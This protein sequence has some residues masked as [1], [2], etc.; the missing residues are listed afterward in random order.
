MWKMGICLF[1]WSCE[2]ANYLTEKLGG[3]SDSCCLQSVA[4]EREVAVNIK[5]NNPD[6]YFY[7]IL[8]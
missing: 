7:L 5:T 2:T 6:S 1:F 4:E 3:R 8:Q